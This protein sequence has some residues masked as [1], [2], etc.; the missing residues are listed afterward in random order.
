MPQTVIPP[1]LITIYPIFPLFIGQADVREHGLVV[2]SDISGG[3]QCLICNN[4]KDASAECQTG[5]PGKGQGTTPRAQLTA[6]S[7]WLPVED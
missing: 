3:L 4:M 1:L 5:L 2:V 7:K 6:N